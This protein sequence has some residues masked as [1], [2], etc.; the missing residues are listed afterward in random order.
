MASTRTTCDPAER[1]SERVLFW[2]IF[3]RW[4]FSRSFMDAKVKDDEWTQQ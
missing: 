2:G 3:E 4:S 1:A